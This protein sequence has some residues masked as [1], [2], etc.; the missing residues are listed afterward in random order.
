MLTSCLSRGLG[1]GGGVY[2]NPFM[3]DEKTGVV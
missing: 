1:G 2:I 3:G